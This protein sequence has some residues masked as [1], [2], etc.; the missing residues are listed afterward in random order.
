MKALF[1]TERTPPK[2]TATSPAAPK[3]KQRAVDSFVALVE[4]KATHGRS[5]HLRRLAGRLED[6][7]C[8]ARPRG[9][10]AAWVHGSVLMPQVFSP[11]AELHS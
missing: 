5:P 7:R 1:L 4:R 3:L 9:K 8:T 10:Q 6:G 2:A 11:A